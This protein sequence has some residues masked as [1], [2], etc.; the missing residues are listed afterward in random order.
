MRCGR[1]TGRSGRESDV[2]RPRVSRRPFTGLATYLRNRRHYIVIGVFLAILAA[3]F[4]SFSGSLPDYFANFSLNMGAE[5]IG[6]MFLLFFIG[7]TSWDAAQYRTDS[8][9]QLGT[10][11]GNKFAELWDAENTRTLDQFN[12]IRIRVGS[13]KDV[14]R[15]RFA[16]E[17]GT[18]FVSG[19][20]I[21]DAYLSRG[22]DQI[23]ARVVDE[24]ANHAWR[25]PHRFSMVP[26]KTG[27][28]EYAASRKLFQRKYGHFDGAVILRLVDAVE[29][30]RSLTQDGSTRAPLDRVR[31]PVPADEEDACRTSTWTTTESGSGR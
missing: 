22:I 8:K 21:V 4:L 2:T 5:L 20:E 27:S 7:P 3:V 19:R 12:H 18:T 23:Q 30:E 31:T 13:D 29:P 25:G 16:S 24:D 14:Y 17:A 28:S 15:L 26:V 6:V 10:F 11:V 1:V 9:P